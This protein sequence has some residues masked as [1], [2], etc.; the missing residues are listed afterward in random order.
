MKTLKNTQFILAAIAM[1][2]LISAKTFAAVDA[3]IWFEDAKGAITKVKV[4]TKDGSFKSWGLVVGTYSMSF[5][6]SRQQV[7]KSVDRTSS[8]P[9]VSEVVVTY[10]IQSPRDA[11]S[12]MATGKRQHGMM[13]ITKEIDK[14]TPLVKSGPGDENP[15]ESLTLNF[16]K[17]TIDSPNDGIS[18]KIVMQYKNGGKASMDDWTAK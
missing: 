6:I 8:A 13:T 4:N 18:G 11:Q 16:G 10:Q 5:H 9:S 17:I 14:S 7:A 15:T 12:G 3:F 2:T 1:I